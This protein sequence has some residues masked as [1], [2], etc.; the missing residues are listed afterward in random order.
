MKSAIIEAAEFIEREAGTLQERSMRIEGLETVWYSD[1]DRKAYFY[2]IDLAQRL[3]AEA[4]SHLVPGQMRCA[5]CGFGLTRTNLYVNSGTTGP[6]DSKTEPCL[7]GCGPLWPVTWEQQ[8][9]EGWEAAGRFLKERNDL[10]DEL[11]AVNESLPTP[12]SKWHPIETAPKDNKRPLWL[13]EFNEDGSLRELDW[14]GAWEIEQESW[15]MPEYYYVW[16]SANGRV[17]EPTHWAYMED[18]K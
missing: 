6:G 14:D 8:A 15:E 12:P 16:C 11:S 2:K 9:K 10:R 13:A 18:E 7:N 17:E 4:T 5:K 3:R 1:V